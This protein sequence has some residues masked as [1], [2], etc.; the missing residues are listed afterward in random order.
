MRARTPSSRWS[1][2]GNTLPRLLSCEAL[3]F[4][5]DV[6]KMDEK[7][8]AQWG[9]EPFVAEMAVDRSARGYVLGLFLRTKDTRAVSGLV[10]RLAATRVAPGTTLHMSSS[11]YT[12]TSKPLRR[13]Q[14]LMR[15][16]AERSRRREP[17]FRESARRW[18]VSSGG[19]AVEMSCCEA[20]LRW[21]GGCSPWAGRATSTCG[22]S[23][24]ASLSPRS[25]ERQAQRR[26]RSSQ[27]LA[28]S[29]T[30]SRRVTR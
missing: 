17:S 9:P 8:L 4:S 5:A 21:Q 19:T 11:A 24:T 13:W 16:S 28:C 23:I 2:L 7:V 26:R 29:A 15:R 18:P 27:R 6:G 12:Y 20:I 30:F 22:A 1:T 3:R 10:A 25:R 14:R